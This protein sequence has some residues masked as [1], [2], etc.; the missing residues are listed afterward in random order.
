MDPF[1]IRVSGACSEWSSDV[2][3]VTIN[4][5]HQPVDLSTEGSTNSST[6]GDTTAEPSGS[7]PA[8]YYTDV[9]SMWNNPEVSTL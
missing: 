7:T 6:I 8:T 2:Q 3:C 9:A 4:V 1:F 5:I